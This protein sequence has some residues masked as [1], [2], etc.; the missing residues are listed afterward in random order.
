[1]AGD[2][3][4][5]FLFLWRGSGTNRLWSGAL[6]RA[7]FC[8]VGGRSLHLE[9]PMFRLEALPGLLQRLDSPCSEVRDAV[10]PASVCDAAP[11][12]RQVL[13]PACKLPSSVTPAPRFTPGGLLRFCYAVARFATTGFTL[14]ARQALAA[15]SAAPH[16][17]VFAARP[18]AASTAR[19]SGRAASARG[20]RRAWQRLR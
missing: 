15:T 17:P 14:P 12:P 4:H 16:R 19:R 6:A 1:M 18:A 5:V 20:I 9:P 10:P 8:V 3:R 11:P 7:P 13:T 2:I